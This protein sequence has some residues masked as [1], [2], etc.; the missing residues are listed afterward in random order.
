MNNENFT[1]NEKHEYQLE[2]EARVKEVIEVIFIRG[3]KTDVPYNNTDRLRVVIQIRE[4]SGSIIAENDPINSKSIKSFGNI[5][6]F[7]LP[8]N[9]K[10]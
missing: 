9:H 10:Y 4:L 8:S 5:G 7:I 2:V 1:E 3:H 6:D